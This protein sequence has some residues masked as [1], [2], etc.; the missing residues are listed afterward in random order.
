MGDLWV[1]KLRRVVTHETEIVVA[2]DDEDEAER[3][4]LEK[5]DNATWAP[6]ADEDDPRAGEPSVVSVEETQ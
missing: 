1:V 2:A 6:S 3:L 4:A 5:A